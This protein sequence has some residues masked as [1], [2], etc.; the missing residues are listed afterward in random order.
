MRTQTLASIRQRIVLAKAIIRSAIIIITIFIIL[1]LLV[2]VAAYPRLVPMATENFY[3]WNTVFLRF[4]A[5]T[6]SASETI[7]NAISP[8]GAVSE[9]INNALISAAPAFRNTI[10]GA[11]S[12]ITSGLVSL[13]PTEKYLIIQNSAAWVVALATILYIQYMKTRRYRR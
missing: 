12:A 1:I 6:I 9:T 8:I 3:Q 2:T 5:A 7:A 4:V 10:E 13:H 11:A